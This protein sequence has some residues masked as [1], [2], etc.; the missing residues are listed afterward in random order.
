MQPA[1]LGIL[2]TIPV[3][4]I[5]VAWELGARDVARDVIERHEA[6]AR[7]VRARNGGHARE[8][9]AQASRRLRRAHSGHAGA[10]NFLSGRTLALLL[11][12]AL[13]SFVA[14]LAVVNPSNQ[15]ANPAALVRASA[16]TVTQRVRI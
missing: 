12:V 11:G 15:A 5:C 13:V 6:R 3:L 8:R 9:A 14:V 7:T 10:S 2:C 4:A 16:A 1:A